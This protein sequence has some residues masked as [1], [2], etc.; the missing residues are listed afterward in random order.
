VGIRKKTQA[1]LGAIRFLGS[2]GA[3]PK[4]FQ[5]DL[6]FPDWWFPPPFQGN[7]PTTVPPLLCFDFYGVVVKSWCEKK[8]GGGYRE[9]GKEKLVAALPFHFRG[10]TFGRKPG[11]PVCRRFDWRGGFVAFR[12]KKKP[13]FGKRGK[14][15]FGYGEKKA[16]PFFFTWGPLKFKERGM[17]FKGRAQWF[18]WNADS[19][20]PDETGEFALCWGNF[21]CRPKKNFAW[22][23]FFNCRKKK[24]ARKK[25]VLRARWEEKKQPCRNGRVSKR[26]GR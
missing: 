16:R 6:Y 3:P 4:F 9:K 14:T 22:A 10:Q 13:C 25:R 12:A 5:K 26:A 24:K 8:G 21:F 11:G 2:I 18:G 19:F 23:R 20:F 1:A 15:L 7:P 17:Y